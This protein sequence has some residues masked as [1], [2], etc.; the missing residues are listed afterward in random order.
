MIKCKKG[1]VEVMGT[2]LDIMA[3]LTC[4]IAAVAKNAPRE[5]MDVAIETGFEVA[6]GKQKK[7]TTITVDGDGL[8]ELVKRMKE[9]KG[10]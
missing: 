1:K 6:E 10:E 4:I 8:M 2:G 7:I 5:L 3:D 9:D